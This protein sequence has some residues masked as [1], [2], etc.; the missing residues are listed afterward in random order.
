MGAYELNLLANLIEEDENRA[1]T[2]TERIALRIDI[3]DGWRGG[4]SRNVVTTAHTR[5][6][7]VP[8][9]ALV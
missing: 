2:D 8:E 3:L 1:F 6:T 7:K 9:Q 4:L 5:P